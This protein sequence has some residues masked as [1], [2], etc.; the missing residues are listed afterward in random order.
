MRPL[1]NKI[2]A[3]FL[4]LGLGFT[5]IAQEQLDFQIS[6]TTVTSGTPDTLEVT[7]QIRASVGSSCLRTSQLYFNYN[8]DAFG[9]NLIDNQQIRV[10]KGA[11]IEDVLFN[12]TTPISIYSIDTADNTSSRLA[13]TVTSTQQATNC[14]DDLFFPGSGSNAHA[15]VGSTWTDFI[16][17]HIPIVD[18]TKLP[19]IEWQS[20]LSSGQQFFQTTS[21]SPEQSALPDSFFLDARIF[22]LEDYDIIWDGG[23]WTG[24]SGGSGEP[25]SA[26]AAL[27]LLVETGTTTPIS[28]N[29]SVQNLIIL[30]QGILDLGGNTLTITGDIIGSVSGFLRNGTIQFSGSTAQTITGTTSWDNIQINN[31]N[32]VTIEND[33]QSVYGVLTLTNGALTT[34]DALRLRATDTSY[35]QIEPGS[36][37]VSGNVTYEMYISQ[38]GWHNLSSPISS[39]TLADLEDDIIINYD[40][41]AAGVSAFQWDAAAGDWTEASANTDNFTGGWNIYIDNNFVDAGGG[42]NADGNLPV[43]LDLTGTPN[44]GTQNAT[45]GYALTPAWSGFE[46]ANGTANDGWNLIANP[47]P[48]NLDWTEVGKGITGDVNAYFYIWNPATNEYVFNDLGGNGNATSTNISPMQAIWV[49][50]DNSGETSTTAFDFVDGERTVSS[51][52]S[53]LKTVTEALKLSV[54]SSTSGLGDQTSILRDAGYST[55]YEASGDA[56]KRASAGGKPS[57]YVISKDSMLLA[58]NRIDESY[59]GDSIMLGF[60]GN[61][62]ENYVIAIAENSFP[63]DFKVE[64]HDLKTGVI[65]DLTSATHAFTNDTAFSEHRFNLYAV[66][67]TISVEE[68]GDGGAGGQTAFGVVTR[69]ESII[70]SFS[71]DLPAEVDI[72]V[73]DISGRVIYEKEGIDAN[74]EFQFSFD[75]GLNSAYIYVVRV[76]D[77][78]T[79]EMWTEK[80][81]Y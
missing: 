1:S 36:G 33:T 41:N 59:M 79:G 17:L 26:D 73:V 2:I 39:M 55:S 61:H 28:G 44:S 15:T 77:P 45:L 7:V 67:K 8:S 19:K 64:L 66:S 38:A 25:N 18:A 47:Y 14:G 16:I 69:G 72:D 80:I 52:A 60:E 58:V 78:E 27:N 10:E 32:G 46:G 81:F 20:T 53:F 70:V 6:N 75:T 9:T 50:L 56:F 49:K 51:P 11:L 4:A 22:P 34:G 42:V 54:T 23:A 57:F 31:A 3:T 29:A 65:V 74:G 5:S 12:G 13:I 24:G 68:P 71:N 35:A 62:G 48:S 37:S 30:D 43:I 21:A 76:K 63:S 40:G